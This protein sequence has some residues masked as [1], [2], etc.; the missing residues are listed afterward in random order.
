MKKNIKKATLAAKH[1]KEKELIKG[2][3]IYE[4]WKQKLINTPTLPD[5]LPTRLNELAAELESKVKDKDVIRV[6]MNVVEM[7]IGDTLLATKIGLFTLK[8]HAICPN[9]VTVNNVDMICNWA[10]DTLVNRDAWAKG[11]ARFA[12]P[13]CGG[14]IHQ[15][16]MKLVKTVVNN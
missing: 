5:E 15:K 4:A 16:S 3:D 1:A 8:V 7:K 6:I 13:T 9:T 10:G 14:L 12:C 11:N 2:R